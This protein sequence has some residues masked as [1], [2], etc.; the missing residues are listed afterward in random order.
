MTYEQLFS[1][2]RGRTARADFL[3][4]LL[5]LA[6]AIAFFMFLVKGRTAQF[7][8]LVLLYPALVLHA[9]RLH[10]MG[11]SGWLLAVPAALLLVWFGGWLGYLDLTGAAAGPLPWATLAASAAVVLWCAT[12]NSVKTPN[13]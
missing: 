3:P 11:R 12:G 6:A 2:P 13:P 10:D 9:R 5:V 7:C 1:D 4:A 8:V